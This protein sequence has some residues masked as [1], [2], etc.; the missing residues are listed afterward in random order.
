ML[1]H[2]DEHIDHAV[3]LGLRQRGIDVTT[4]T[5]AELLGASDEQQLEFARQSGC[6]LLTQD[7]DLLRLHQQGIHHAGIV[8]PLPSLGRWAN[9]S[10]SCVYCTIAWTHWRCRM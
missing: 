1:F 6:V 3:A 4:T 8:S 10:V 9:W 5:D 7:S 2:L